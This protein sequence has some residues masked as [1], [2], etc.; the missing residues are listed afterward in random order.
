MGNLDDHHLQ[1]LTSESNYVPKKKKQ[2]ISHQE[3]TKNILTA[4][5]ILSNFP[6]LNKVN[7]LDNQVTRTAVF[8]H[9]FLY[10]TTLCQ[11]H[12]LYSIK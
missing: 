8:L 1:H 9:L 6:K 5:F 3:K 11:L 7:D 4:S 2:L 10:L 12:T